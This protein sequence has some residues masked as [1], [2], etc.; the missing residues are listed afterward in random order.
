MKIADLTNPRNN[1]T[2]RFVWVDDHDSHVIML[3]IDASGTTRETRNLDR[4]T[5]RL[6]WKQMI[7][8]GWEFDKASQPSEPCEN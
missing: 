7:R 5:A 3:E 8:A 6:I 2:A 1:F 4:P